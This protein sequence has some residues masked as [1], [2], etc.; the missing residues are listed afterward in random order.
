MANGGIIGP[1]NDPI[2]E[3][4][5]LVTTFTASGC[6]TARA[7]QPSI[8]ATIV[9]GGGAG[10]AEIGGA[11]GAGGLKTVCGIP[12][13]GTISIVVGAG[14]T[15]ASRPAS[16]GNGSPSSVGCVSSTGGGG[17]ASIDSRCGSTGGSGGGGGYFLCGS[18]GEGGTG[19]CGEGNSGG[20]AGSSPNP[21]STGGGGGGGKSAVGNN[22]SPGGGGSGGAGFDVSP[23]YPGTPLPN[24][25]VYAGGGGGGGYLPA[26]GGAGGP[27]GGGAGSTEYPCATW[28]L[29]NSY[30]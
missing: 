22:G 12:V 16:G 14:G 29:R 1:V 21:G 18:T 5:E 15:K 30:S 7:N 4:T 17:G 8:N 19:T 9:A 26:P 27:G 20:T 28:W 10:G 13:T 11:G 2:I 6:F 24:S 23:L 3:S 25:G